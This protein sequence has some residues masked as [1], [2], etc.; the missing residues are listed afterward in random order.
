MDYTLLDSLR[1]RFESYVDRSGG[2]EACHPWKGHRG[3][4]D[5]GTFRV[6]KKKQKAHRVAWALTH[7]PIPEGKFVCHR[8]DNP[9][10]CNDAH[11]FLGTAADN[12]TDKTRKGRAPSGERNGNAK[13]SDAQV[14]EAFAMRERGALQREIAERFGVTQSHISALLL[15]QRKPTNH[16]RGECS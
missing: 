16:A 11:L 14:E 3:V 7:G 9:P 4:G 6:G 10:C 5:Y 15:G 2:P 1:E 13:L 8:C 12:M